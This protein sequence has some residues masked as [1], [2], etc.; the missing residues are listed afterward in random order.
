MPFFSV[1]IPVYN[2]ENYIEECVNSVLTQTYDD[3]EIIIVDDGSKDSSSLI[4]D[5]IAEKDSRIRVIHKTNGGLSSARNA[6]IESSI[7]KYL[8]FIDGDDVLCDNK[9]FQIIYN[10]LQIEY[11][12]VVSY[13]RE[14]V[15]AKT[16]EI[17]PCMDRRLEESNNLDFKKMIINLISNDIFYGSAWVLCTNRNFIVNNNLFFQEGVTTED[18]D[19]IMRIINSYPKI[20]NLENVFYRYRSDRVGSITRSV[21]FK[22]QI[23]YIN[24]IDKYITYEYMDFEMRDILLN[25]VAYQYVIYCAWNRLIADKKERK[26]LINKEK[27]YRFL[28][29]YDLMPQTKITN[30]VSKI[31]GFTLTNK[32]LG[33]KLKRK[34]KNR[35]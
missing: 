21:N 33:I 1:I 22:R 15:S 16:G 27:K 2:I 26:I 20:Y 24:F 28:L 23:E 13:N 9:C 35:G 6:G 25:Y 11:Y 14:T 12:D 30:K 3:Y 10:K 34:L 18:F 4:C 19:W 31:I 17:F 8:I 29:K 7:G 32:L 5:R